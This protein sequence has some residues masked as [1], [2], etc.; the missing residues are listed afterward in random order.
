MIKPNLV[1][2]SEGHPDIDT[3]FLLPEISVIQSGF[4]KITV[5]PLKWTGN[6]FSGTIPPNVTFVKDLAHRFEKRASPEN[7]I[8]GVFSSLFWKKL[9]STKPSKYK[10]LLYTCAQIRIVENWIVE[11]NYEKESTL[12]YSYWLTLPAVSLSHLK[13]KKLIQKFIVRAHGFDLYNERGEYILNSFKPYVFRNCNLLFCISENGNKYLSDLYPDH[14]SKFITSRLGVPDPGI[15][16]TTKPKGFSLLSCSFLSPV[17]R[18]DLLMEGICYFQKKYPEINLYWT[19]IGGGQF[20]EKIR[21]DAEKKLLPGTFT[22]AGT[23]EPSEIQEY[24]SQTF[25]DCFINVSESEGIP[26]SMMEAQSFGIPILATKVGGTPEIV[27]EKNG[28]LL[29]P[30]PDPEEIS[31]ALFDIIMNASI[32]QNKRI[33]SRKSWEEYFNASRN[34]SEFL[35]HLLKL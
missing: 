16:N 13:E 20:F 5:C 8:S 9:I 4:N 1:I 31:S 27:N 11:M 3:G 15:Y 29:S 25:F 6:S 26:V 19:H 18:I 2:I 21:S 28:K 32:W 30:N 7:K 22:L 10:A 24:Y 14:Q 34:Y 33:N 12:F 23:L 17:K 35:G